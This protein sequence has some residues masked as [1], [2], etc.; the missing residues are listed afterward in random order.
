MSR[1]IGIRFTLISL[2]LI[3]LFLAGLCKAQDHSPDPANSFSSAGQQK[4]SVNLANLS[5]EEL[6]NIETKVSSASRQRESLAHA[7]AAIF[8]VT[9]EDIR[10]GG[11]SSIAEALPTVPGRHVPTGTR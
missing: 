10:R 5:L 9:A 7:P 6:M 2:F 11:C 4:K 3:S 1:R 8:V